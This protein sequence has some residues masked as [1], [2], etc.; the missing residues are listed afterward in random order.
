MKGRS[1]G[2]PS[3]MVNHLSS[4]LP[5]LPISHE[6]IYQTFRPVW[7]HKFQYHWWE[8]KRERERER[9]SEW[10]ID[11]IHKRMHERIHADFSRNPSFINYEC[12]QRQHRHM[13]LNIQHKLARQNIEPVSIWHTHTHRETDR[14]T[15]THT[16]QSNHY[17]HLVIQVLGEVVK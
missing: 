4:P 5:L 13:Y 1:G 16:V 17:T 14:E 9:E 3:V 10:V 6:T 8:R 15:H 12:I 11:L 2:C 7:Y